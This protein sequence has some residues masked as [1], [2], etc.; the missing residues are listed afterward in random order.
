[1]EKT[2]KCSLIRRSRTKLC[3]LLNFFSSLFHH[4][5]NIFIAT[6]AMAWLGVVIMFKLKIYLTPSHHH[7]YYQEH[8]RVST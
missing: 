6:R 5:P 3:G 8:D 2:E 7:H 4:H 1:M